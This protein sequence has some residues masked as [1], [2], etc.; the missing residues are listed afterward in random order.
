[1]P[2]ESIFATTLEKESVASVDFLT[3]A[4]INDGEPVP[5]MIK[6]QHNVAAVNQMLCDT[7]DVAASCTP[8]SGPLRA[9]SSLASYLGEGL[10]RDQGHS[11]SCVV[12]DLRSNNLL[13][14][15]D[16]I[17]I[18]GRIPNLGSIQV[19]RDAGNQALGFF[20][21]IPDFPVTPSG[22]RNIF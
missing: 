16:K 20:I 9:V 15:S 22:T 21:D 17:E 2:P 12:L 5:I 13:N 10:I 6:C 18:V 11:E 8:C 14:P 3:S 7:N 1:M 19:N 4:R